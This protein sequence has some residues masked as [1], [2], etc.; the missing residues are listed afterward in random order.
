MKR[1]KTFLQD[2]AFLEIRKRIQNGTY[3]PGA[4]LSTQE[5][6]DSLGIS[7]TPVVA[8]INRLVAQGVADAIP[9]RGV[10]VAKITPRRILETVDIRMMIERFCVR[11]AIKNLDYVPEIVSEM[12][13]VADALQTTEDFNAAYELE[14]RFHTLFVKLAGNEK[15][16]GIYESNW[17]I[18]SIFFLWTASSTNMDYLWASL[19]ESKKILELLLA[20]DAEA[21]ED[22]IQQHIQVVYDTID[23]YIRQ[24]MDQI[25]MMPKRL[26]QMKTM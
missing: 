11:P 23:W 4:K 20:K 9:N 10:T 8:A 21:L 19:K 25:T 14:S 3:P 2:Y 22:F 16:L 5:I 26:D 18:G 13:E 7:R 15:L 12:Q 1:E 24:G 6:S 17:S